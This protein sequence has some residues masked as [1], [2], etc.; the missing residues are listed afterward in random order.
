MAILSINITTESYDH[1]MMILSAAIDTSKDPIEIR[2]GFTDLVTALHQM[3]AVRN[4]GKTLST[5]TLGS[6][7]LQITLPALSQ[8]EKDKVT[9]LNN[10]VDMCRNSISATNKTI[11]LV[12]EV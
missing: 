7:Q 6:G 5:V 4:S 10:M 8:T 9:E 3:V 12:L 1:L 11:K 2:T